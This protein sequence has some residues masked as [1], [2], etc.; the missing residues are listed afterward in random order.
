MAQ[1][2]YRPTEPVMVYEPLAPAPPEVPAPEPP[3]ERT[4]KDHPVLWICVVVAVF[5]A[6][7]FFANRS[8][9]VPAA[10]K[11]AQQAS[12]PAAEPAAPVAETVAPAP[13]APRTATPKST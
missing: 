11:P 10:A 9:R 4:W 1:D 8:A 6:V 2:D 3:P 12:A 7:P 5:M 13:E